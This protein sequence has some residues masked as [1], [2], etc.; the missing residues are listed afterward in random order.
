MTRTDR[1]DLLVVMGVAG[2]GKSSIA[3]E[4]AERV[5]GT[6]L[7]GDDFHPAANI[8]RMRSGIPLEDPD[9]LP[10]LRSIRDRVLALAGGSPTILSC[11]ALKESYRRILADHPGRTEFV[12][13]DP[14]GE[15]IRR[16][17][18]ARRGHFAGAALLDSQYAILETPA[19]AFVLAE[20][21]P[22]PQLASLV[23]AH[24]FQS[25]DEGAT[26]RRV[27][28]HTPRTAPRGSE[29]SA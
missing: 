1:P 24:F 14:P 5:G 16:R 7:E 11:S 28:A 8:E 12:F 3:K 29:D 19:D 10:W 9:R 6:F 25:P 13:L 2:S 21:L 26:D 17:L 15:T 20:P 22:I 18:E 27:V 23:V 4:V